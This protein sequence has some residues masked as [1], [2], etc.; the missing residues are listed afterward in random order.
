MHRLG[1]PDALTDPTLP[2]VPIFRIG[3]QKAMNVNPLHRFF[4]YFYHL[5]GEVEPKRG[6]GFTTNDV[7]PSRAP[8]R[9]T[10]PAPREKL[11][12][13][14]PLRG[15]SKKLHDLLA[16]EVSH[17]RETTT[18]SLSQ[19]TCT[20]AR[21]ATASINL[22]SVTSFSLTETICSQAATAPL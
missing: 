18:R 22:R 2:V 6:R 8:E 14:R 5:A 21:S 19:V 4:D 20:P 9:P 16:G 7:A 13:A 11:K 10:S 17:E 12:T 15:R 1:R 3:N